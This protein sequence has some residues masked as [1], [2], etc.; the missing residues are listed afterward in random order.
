MLTT[1]PLLVPRLRKSRSYTSSYP[2]APLWSVTGPLYPTLLQLWLHITTSSP[3][4][5]ISSFIWQIN[6]LQS[7]EC[8]YCVAALLDTNLRHPDMHSSGT[9]KIF[10]GYAQSVHSNAMIVIQNVTRPHSKR[11]INWESNSFLGFWD[12]PISNNTAERCRVSRR[13]QVQV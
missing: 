6:Y 12:W 8:W 2:N 5:V 7:E 1:R 10:L 13:H 4:P 3:L 11:Y 9:T